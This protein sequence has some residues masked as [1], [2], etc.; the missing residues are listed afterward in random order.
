MSWLYSEV[1]L[2]AEN[3]LS[4]D[5]GAAATLQ[6]ATTQPTSVDARSNEQQQH[7]KPGKQSALVLNV[8]TGKLS[9]RPDLSLH[10]YISQPPCGDGS[11]VAVSPHHSQQD[12]S[13]TLPNGHSCPCAAMAVPSSSGSDQSET[14]NAAHTA[15]AVDGTEQS[16]PM[17]LASGGVWYANEGAVRFRTGAKAIRLASPVDAAAP[18]T[19]GCTDIHRGLGSEALVPAITT[20]RAVV[21][22]QAGSSGAGRSADRGAGGVSGAVLV[23]QASEVEQGLQEL[24]ALRRKP[25]KVVGGG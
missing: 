8:T 13:S 4:S 21:P 15:V 18:V 22:A 20:G 5:S 12:E 1:Q 19:M 3:A 2:A 11:I 14:H 10:M 7:P 24:G 9:L 23:P 25:G 16:L 6:G 17:S